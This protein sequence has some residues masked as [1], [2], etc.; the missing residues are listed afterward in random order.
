MLTGTITLNPVPLDQTCGSVYLLADDTIPV[1][2]TAAYEASLDGGTTWEPVT[3][4]VAEALAHQGTQFQMRA[5]LTLDDLSDNEGVIRW[6]IGYA[7]I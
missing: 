6:F 4:G 2:G 5:T 7:T 3:P 1:D